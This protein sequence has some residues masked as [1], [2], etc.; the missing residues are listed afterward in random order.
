[1]ECSDCD[2]AGVIH[3]RCPECDG[4]PCE[5]GGT[6]CS[7]CGGDGAIEPKCTTCDGAGEIEND[8]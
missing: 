7:T 6:G 2:G 3:R 8:E 5:I 1:M 4:K